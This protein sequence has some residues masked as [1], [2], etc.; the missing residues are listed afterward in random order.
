MKSRLPRVARR[1]R[2]PRTPRPPRARRRDLVAEAISGILQR[3]GRSALTAF[4]TVLGVAVLIVVLGL[5]SS[6]SAQIDSR[7]DPKTATEVSVSSGV[8]DASS[9]LP[10][11]SDAVPRALRIDGTVT[12]G[13]GY[14]LSGV[15]GQ[16]SQSPSDGSSATVMA[17]TPGFLDG[18]GMVSDTGAAI[19]DWH[20][21]NAARVALLGP[22]VARAIGY[23]SAHSGSAI[24]VDGVRFAVAGVLTDV[25]A[26]PELLTAVSIPLSVALEL[27]P[28]AHSEATLWVTT[29]MGAAQVV[30]AQ[31][32]LA[33]DPSFPDR[34]QVTTP[35]DPLALRE[36]VASDLTTLFVLLGVACLIVGMV[37][38]ANTTFVAVIERTPEIGLRR[39]VGAH[40]SQILGQ[41][42]I[43]SVIL[44][45]LGGLV[46]SALGVLSVVIVCLKRD[47][48]AVLDWRIAVSGPLLGAVVGM[49]AGA[50]PAWRASR[51]EPIAAL[52]A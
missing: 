45:L 9:L 26:H 39:A 4:G 12:A 34:L 10:L 25:E 13:F 2:E 20:Q 43:E 14:P 47:W 6:A 40:P 52:R 33:I 19:N 21:D 51:I 5:T 15:R 35:P 22:Q 46:G 37:S 24:W 1:P 42:L 44:G 50:V 8:P 18:I 32:A 16:V 29:E 17:V 49:I 36:S 38:I 23:G 3:P 41:F 28:N 30:G 31:I 27:F 7:F 11:P 48:T